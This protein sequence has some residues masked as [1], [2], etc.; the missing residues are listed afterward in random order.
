MLN[1]GSVAYGFVELSDPGMF[2][3]D[4]ASE[5]DADDFMMMN[6]AIDCRPTDILPIQDED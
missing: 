1:Q 3:A 6:A 4:F 5:E 2:V